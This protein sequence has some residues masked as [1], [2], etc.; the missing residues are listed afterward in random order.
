MGCLQSTVM[1]AGLVL[2]MAMGAAAAVPSEGPG[3]RC[4]VPGTIIVTTAGISI[5]LRDGAPMHCVSRTNGVETDTILHLIAS[6]DEH[7]SQLRDEIGKIWPL[8]VGYSQVFYIGLPQEPIVN[9]IAVTRKAS[10]DVPA[11]HFDTYV[12]EW[13]Q[14][15]ANCGAILD[16]VHRYYYAPG[17]ATIVKYE[18]G[19]GYGNDKLPDKAADWDALKIMVPGDQAAPAMSRRQPQPVRSSSNERGAPQY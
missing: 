16:E 19:Y 7:A 6:S 13:S 11:G 12:I 17:P 15:A 8:R 10:V 2:G 4:P 14:F 9:H 1:V 18:H 3:F 5:A